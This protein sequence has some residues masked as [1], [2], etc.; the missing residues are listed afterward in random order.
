MKTFTLPVVIVMCVVLSACAGRG[1]RD[2]ASDGD[3]GGSRPLYGHL[4]RDCAAADVV[5]AA[6]RRFESDLYES[7]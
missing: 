7:L 6:L 4:V 1:S 5:S 2:A 3:V